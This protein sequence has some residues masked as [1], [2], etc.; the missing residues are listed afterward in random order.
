MKK[1]RRLRWMAAALAAVTIL[2]ACGQEQQAVP[3]PEDAASAPGEGTSAPGTASPNTP[4][5]PAS[6]AR[7]ISEPAAAPE[8]LESPAAPQAEA[9]V[10]A[11]AW[12]GTWRWAESDKYN[13]AAIEIKSV[14]ERQ[15]VFSLMAFHV[16]NMKTMDGSHGNIENGVAEMV[17]NEAVF[18]DVEDE[19]FEL[20]MSL[21]DD[22]LTVTT[23]KNYIG[24]G[25]FVTVDGAYARWTPEPAN[26]DYLVVPGQ[27]LG[28]ISL[29]MTQDEVIRQLGQPAAA[30]E[31]RMIY[32]SSEHE[33]VLYM[34]EQTV[35]QIAFSSPAFSTAEGV[36]TGNHADY[37]D[38]FARSEY[39]QRY[40]HLREEWIEGGLAFFTF[41]SD[42]PEGDTEQRQQVRGYIYEGQEMYE[43]PLSEAEWK[44][45]GQ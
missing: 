41:N 28:K 14:D 18:T 39:R 43:E 33:I 13:S 3:A 20:R 17:G 9:P 26:T 7:T 37:G 15:M 12:L 38:F 8:T 32:Q 29:G 35:R 40:L 30:E 27:S 21:G 16:T 11:S 34:E 6:T 44:P 10:N 45:V 25:A 36:N 24:F 1:I 2:T 22:H 42:A 4:S 5:A 31:N 23:N 19:D